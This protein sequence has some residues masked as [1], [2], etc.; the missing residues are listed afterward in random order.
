MRESHKRK[1]WEKVTREKDGRKKNIG[2]RLGKV[3]KYQQ[4]RIKSGL[5]RKLILPSNPSLQVSFN[6][7]LCQSMFALFLLF[8]GYRYW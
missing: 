7:W 8:L 5:Q 1:S 2:E 6:T 4:D 3:S